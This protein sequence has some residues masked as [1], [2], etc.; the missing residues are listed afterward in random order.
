M[1]TGY[2]AIVE[3][4]PVF[5]PFVIVKLAPLLRV[6][7]TILDVCVSV[8]DWHIALLTVVFG[9]LIVEPVNVEYCIK[10][11]TSELVYIVEQIFDMDVIV[12]PVSVEYVTVLVVL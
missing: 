12:E 2:C 8:N 5:A 11:E 10:F 6:D 3:I 1:S 4:V 9:V 7:V